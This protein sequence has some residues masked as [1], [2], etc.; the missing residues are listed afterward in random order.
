MNFMQEKIKRITP[1]IVTYNSFKLS[2][3]IIEI[4]SIF[5]NAIVV[6][7]STDRERK[8]FHELNIHL[9]NIIFIQN[10]KNLGY[11]QANNKGLE[12]AKTEFALIINPDVEITVDAI[13]AMLNC[14]DR[15]TN[16]MIVGCNVN[17]TR[18]NTQFNSYN[19]NYSNQSLSEYIHP[20]GDVSTLWLSGCC[21]L[22][23]VDKFLKI[24]GFDPNLF[25][26]YEEFDICHRAH[27]SGMECILAAQAYVN[28]ESSASSTP[29]IKVSYIKQ[30]HWSRS[31]RIF[32]TK[33]GIKKI[34]RLG[35]L[36]KMLINSL[37]ALLAIFTFQPSRAIKYIA[38]THSY[39]A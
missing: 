14:A 24:G 1:I 11:G 37:L 27:I 16:A 2:K 21:L 25:M 9:Q 13:H 10:I 18:L 17:D 4:A 34:S 15:Y 39:I 22:V 20:A 5:T 36:I 7:N 3:N 38:R 35:R 12:L 33:Y 26:Y 19:W 31:K 6:N 23:R 29:S 30:L 8:L 32:Q 28:H